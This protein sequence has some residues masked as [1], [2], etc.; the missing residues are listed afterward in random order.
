MQYPMPAAVTGLDHDIDYN[1]VLS[2]LDKA[3]MCIMYPRKKPLVGASKWTF[4]YALAK[5][6]I[7]RED[8]KAAQVILDA[9]TEQKQR[10]VIDASKI[11]TLFSSWC[12]KTHAVAMAVKVPELAGKRPG[13]VGSPDQ[14]SVGRPLHGMQDENRPRK[15]ADVFI[16]P[17]LDMCSN[18]DRDD[19]RGDVNGP[20]AGLGPRPPSAAAGLRP[21]GAASAV[22]DPE[23]IKDMKLDIPKSDLPQ[24]Y[25]RIIK[26]AIEGCPVS[27]KFPTMLLYPNEYRKGV[28]EQCLREWEKYASV[29]FEHS[30]VEDAELIYVF[31][32][33]N[34]ETGEAILRTDEKLR[35]YCRRTK[36]LPKGLSDMP[37]VCHTICLR[38]ISPEKGYAETNSAIDVSLANGT[39]TAWT[40]KNFDQRSIL[41]EVGRVPATT[42]SGRRQGSANAK[43]AIDWPLSGPRP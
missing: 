3:Y 14:S 7:T 24:D 22:I 20:G 6:G 17:P 1:Y 26:W 8:P 41:H 32:D 9:Y 35:S 19:R 13:D 37:Q 5:T 15:D 11:R 42:L 28:L 34:Y 31:Q 39:K 38:G 16:L 10:E 2:D 25:T 27:A 43:G 36:D 18:V 30:T 12:Q 23:W 4:E 29:K 21:D 40:N 33:H